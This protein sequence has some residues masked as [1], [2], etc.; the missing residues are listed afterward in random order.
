MEN[1]NDKKVDTSWK[2]HI[3]KEKQHAK[4]AQQTY[5]EPTFSVFVS[6]LAMQA[7]I[8]VGKLENPVTNKTEQNLEQARFL[9]DTLGIIQEKTTNNLTPE[10]YRL[11]EDALHN[12]R[13]VYVEEKNK[14]A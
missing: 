2:E 12:L 5:H 10:E 11:L 1:E 3:D 13:L 7:M 6:S 9:I 8:A 4:D 14:R